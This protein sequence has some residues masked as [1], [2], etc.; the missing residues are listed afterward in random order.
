M[1]ALLNDKAQRK[2]YYEYA[3]VHAVLISVPCRATGDFGRITA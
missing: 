2:F 3:D 1:Y